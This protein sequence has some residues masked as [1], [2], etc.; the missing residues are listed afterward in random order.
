MMSDIDTHMLRVDEAIEEYA[1]ALLAYQRW[2]NEW[3]E[4]RRQ[5]EPLRFMQLDAKLESAL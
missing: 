2:M 4:R 1:E 3:R 5:R